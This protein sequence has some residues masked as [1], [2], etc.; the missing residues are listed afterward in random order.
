MEIALPQRIYPF[1]YPIGRNYYFFFFNAPRL[2]FAYLT[3]RPHPHLRPLREWDEGAPHM[4][5]W[6][7]ACDRSSQVGRRS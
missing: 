7:V 6:Q 2:A 3:A 5:G 4:S 1:I